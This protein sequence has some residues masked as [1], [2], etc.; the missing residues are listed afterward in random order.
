MSMAN[1]G[2]SWLGF[3]QKTLAGF[4]QMQICIT[5]FLFSTSIFRQ[6]AVLVVLTDVPHIVTTTQ[7]IAQ[8][9]Y[10]YTYGPQLKDF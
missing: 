5:V 1:L 6:C 10:F 9:V 7:E 8:W 4:V 3:V 2:I